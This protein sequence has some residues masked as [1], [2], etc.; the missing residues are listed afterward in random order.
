MTFEFSSKANAFLNKIL[1]MT[2]NGESS[3]AG[4]GIVASPAGHVE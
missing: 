3:P 2:L 4:A 1:S